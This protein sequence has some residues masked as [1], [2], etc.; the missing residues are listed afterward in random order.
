MSMPLSI[1]ISDN[2]ERLVS[3]IR[4]C[5]QVV[6]AVGVLATVAC[7]LFDND[8]VC[9]AESRPA[10]AVVV[11]DSSTGV[12]IGSA[13]VIARDGA[14]RDSVTSGPDGNVFLAEGRP[15]RYDVEVR[16][17]GKRNWNVAGVRVTSDECGPIRVT[18]QARLQ[19]E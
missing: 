1:L 2:R 14:F 7:A 15:G 8:V 3:R 5:A 9:T 17:T 6:C 18:L 4:I 13:A 12:P 19:P 11:T 10:L 16:A